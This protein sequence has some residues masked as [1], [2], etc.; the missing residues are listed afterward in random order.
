MNRC[1][2]CALFVVLLSS[3]AAMAA[4]FP[5]KPIRV[6]VPWPPG[7][8]TDTISRIV[9]QRLTAIA[10]QQVVIDNRPGVAGTIGADIASRANPDGYT[11]TIVEASHVIMPATTAKLP[12]DLARDFAPLTQVG[13]SPQI[14]FMHA[15]LPAKSLK[16]FIALARAKPG[17]VPVAHTGIGSFTHLMTEMFQ[18]RTGLKF[19]Q[20]S[21]KGAGPAFIELASGDVHLYMATLASG[22]PT[23]RT[24]RVAAIAVAS[25]KRIAVLPEVPTLA[26]LGIKDMVV[27]QWWGFVAPVRVPGAVQARLHKDLVAA[28]DHVSVRERVTELAVDVST[29]SPD[30][31]KAFIA[32]EL[33]R[34]AAVARDAG[35]KPQ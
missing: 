22:A 32:A 3:A 13:V 20:V 2:R 29:S 33:T 23:L 35:L 15:G 18:A 27:I 10:G 16:D 5:T 7:G 6:I 24:G 9:G 31:L 1:V 30:R 25:E 26:E 8:S 34:W 12:Y 21:Y 14:L 17:Q 28:I 19:N 4:D 11:I